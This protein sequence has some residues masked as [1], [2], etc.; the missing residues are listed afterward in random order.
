M[1][2]TH[3]H[4]EKGL[5]VLQPSEL[6]MPKRLQEWLILHE[7]THFRTKRTHSS[8]RFNGIMDRLMPDNEQR[9]REYWNYRREH[10]QELKAFTRKLAS[11]KTQNEI[12][13]KSPEGK[14]EH[15]RQLEK[16]TLTRLKR[17]ET[18]LKKIQR[19][20]KIWERK[21]AQATGVV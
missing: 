1:N 16:K 5:I 7:V 8:K 4:P 2:R 19:R 13:R 12:Y 20:I 10:E 18:H 3:A 11:Q 17:A 21:Q 6:A 14:L 9:W 15:L